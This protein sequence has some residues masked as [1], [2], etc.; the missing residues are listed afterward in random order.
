MPLD[1]EKKPAH[2]QLGELEHEAFLHRWLLWEGHLRNLSG[3]LDNTRY[4]LCL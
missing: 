2:C 4:V 1:N 3:V